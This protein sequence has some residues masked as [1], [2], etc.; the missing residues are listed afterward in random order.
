MKVVI[1]F[2]GPHKATLFLRHCAFLAVF[3]VFLYNTKS[4]AVK[5][6]VF[7]GL[8]IKTKTHKTS[9]LI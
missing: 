3:F 9:F 6:P 8:H 7:L 2:Q 4:R 5:A 1:S